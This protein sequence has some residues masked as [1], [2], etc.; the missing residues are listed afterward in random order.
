MGRVSTGNLTADRTKF[1]NA[2]YG[3]LTQG[4]DRE[5][6]QAQEQ[7]G[8]DLQNRGIPVGSDAYNNTMAAFNQNWNNRYDQARNQATIGGGNEQQQQ[9]GMNEQVIANQFKQG[10]DVRNQGVNEAT[11]FS[12]IG[13]G[14]QLPNF[15]PFQGAANAGVSPTDIAYKQMVTK[16][17]GITANAQAAALGRRNTGRGRTP[18][19]PANPFVA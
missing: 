4:F 7:Q 13:T 16:N 19:P 12:N 10:Q 15:T 14:A 5:H 17:Q 1:E 9:V 2:L 3:H 6:M 8:Q 18:P 11:T